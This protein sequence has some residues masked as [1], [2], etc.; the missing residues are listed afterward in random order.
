MLNTQTH[1]IYLIALILLIAE[2]FL[3]SQSIDAYALIQSTSTSG[4]YK[5]FG[6]FGSLAKLAVLAGFIFLLLIRN[7]I[8]EHLGR[9]AQGF[10]PKSGLIFGLLHLVSFFT[11][12]KLSVYIFD[13]PSSSHTV[14]APAFLGWI[15]LSIVWISFWLLAIAPVSTLIA[16]LKQERKNILI[17]VAM[18]TAVWALAMFTQ[19]LWGPLS[20]LTFIFSTL[21]LAAIDKKSLTV[22]IDDR[23]L[24]INDF[25]VH[26]AEACSGY[27]GIGLVTA[28]VA[29]YLHIYKKEFRFPRA[30]LLFP[31]GIIIIWLLNVVRIAVLILI[32]AHWSPEVAVGGFHSQAGWLSFIATSLLMLWISRSSGVF[33]KLTT[34]KEAPKPTQDSRPGINTA[35]ATLLPMIALLA[36]IMLSSAFSSGFDILYPLRVIAVA[37][38][39]AFCWRQLQL[40]PEKPELV[41]SLVAIGAGLSVAILWLLMHNND[42]EANTLFQQNLSSM[43]LAISA[44]W[45]AFRFVG[46]VLTVPI[47]EEL[48]FRGYAL[49]RLG[50]QPVEVRGKMAISLFAIVSSSLAFGLLHGAWLAGSI[51]GIIY[52][53][54]RIRCKDIRAAIFSHG[55]TNALLFT[56]AAITGTWSLL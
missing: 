7:N 48:A 54:V 17:T 43:P 8:G 24:G 30:F 22:N 37:L 41:T 55:L 29:I 52:A 46:S 28:F 56:Y 26:I 16:T 13:S 45:L 40:W 19:N 39:L 3:L 14:E 47:A 21:L 9:F 15:A 20:D 2:V 38:T 35:M 6:H 5:I 42:L 49:C 34:K 36:T 33:S 10:K 25:V 27:E 51:A 12:Y 53:M 32:G 31:L 1:R 18:S 44:L 23:I 11:F 50:N 4:W